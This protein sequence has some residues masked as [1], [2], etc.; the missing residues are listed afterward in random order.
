MRINTIVAVDQNWGIGCQGQLLV[1]L[2]QD[3][4]FFKQMT[5]GKTVVMGEVTFCSLPGQK[6]LPDRRNIVLSF[7]PDFKPAGVVVCHSVAE[8]ERLLAEEAVDEVWIIGGASV[9]EQFLPCCHAAHIT[10]IEKAFT[11]DRYFP[12]LQEKSE[13]QCTFVGELEEHEGIPFRHVIYENRQVKK[14]RDII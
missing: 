4:K 5:I 7:D 13:W 8:L 14:L 11:A 12:D 2:P 1:H 3:L 6:P 10:Q 9:Y